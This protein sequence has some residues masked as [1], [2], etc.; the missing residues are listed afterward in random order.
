MAFLNSA[1]QPLYKD[2][3]QAQW[4]L[5]IEFPN[6]VRNTPTAWNYES[7]YIFG[8]N[9]LNPGFYS[10]IPDKFKTETTRQLGEFLFFDPILSANNKRACASCHDP[11]KAFTDGKAKSPGY[12]FNGTVK[13]NS[14]TLLNCI[15]AEKFFHDLRA[16]ALEDQMEHVVTDAKEFNT[17]TNAILE[18]LQSSAEYRQLFDSAFRGYEG[19]AINPQTLSF[20]ISAYVSSLHS[21]NSP[22]DKYARGESATLSMDAKAGFNLFMGKAACGTCHF[23][24][25]FSGLV[26]PDFRES[27]SEVLGVPVA[28]PAKKPVADTD[29]GRGE[30]KLKEMVPF[31]QYSFKTPTVRNIAH[32]APYMHNGGMK[33]LEHVMDFYNKGGGNGIGLQYEYQTLSADPLKLSRKEIKQIIAFMNSLSDFSRFTSKPTQLPAMKDSTLNKRKI[34]GEY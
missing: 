29:K 34:G 15:Y 25:V 7:D 28:W 13:R 8:D 16:E 20:A 23:A 6:E 30:S 18:K 27:E 3:K 14:P 12:D 11:A 1:I 5:E 10:G 19:K 4:L 2:I 31:Y 22:F 32:T 21:F 26:P 9:F 17:S 33:T 24:P